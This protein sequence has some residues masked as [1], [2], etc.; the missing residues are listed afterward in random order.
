MLDYLTDALQHA[1]SQPL[2]LLLAV[3]L[4]LF[5]AATS[6]CCA[7]PAL[8]VMIGYSGTQ[9]NTNKKLSAKLALFFTLGTIVSLLIIGGIAGFIGQAANDNLG[10][11]WK[12]FAGVVLIIFGM[13]ALN[14]FPVKFSFGNIETIKKRLGS[15]SVILTG[16]ILGGLV[17]ITSLCCIPAIFIVMGVAIIQGQ[18]IKAILLLFMFAIGFSIPLGIIVLGVS[19]SKALFLPKK[20]EK[21][22]RWISGGILLIVGFYFLLTF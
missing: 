18:I 19:L 8:G 11:Y 3:T 5:S 2:G 13:A 15:S 4:G 7:V 17:S 6:A 16:F 20:T 9:E 10:K 22:I 1:A 12:V 14:I 21:I